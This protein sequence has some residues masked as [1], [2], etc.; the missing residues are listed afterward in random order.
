MLRN[1]LWS[2]CQIF[3]TEEKQNQNG[4]QDEKVV[5]ELVLDPLEESGLEQ[6]A[7]CPVGNEG[8]QEEKDDGNFCVE[9][10]SDQSPMQAHNGGGKLSTKPDRRS[11]NNA[12]PLDAK[13]EETKATFSPPQVSFTK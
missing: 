7:P 5:D 11:Q 8:N 3:L 4:D 1:N 13:I 6:L 2:K 9:K 10:A 12:G